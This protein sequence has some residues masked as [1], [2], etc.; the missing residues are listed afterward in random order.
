MRTQIDGN[1]IHE[2]VD[3][4]AYRGEVL[5]IIGTSGGGKTTLLREIIGLREPNGGTVEI[6]GQ[7]VHRLEWRE[8]HELRKRWGMMFQQ[9]ALFSALSVFDNVAFPLRELRKRGEHL[10]DDLVRQLVMFKLQ[11]SGLSAD[12]AN[13]L[14][15]TL[16]GGMIKRVALAR[17]LAVE[18]ELLFLDEPASG[19]DPETAR[20]LDSVLKD[21]HEELNLSVVMVSHDLDSVAALADRIIILAEKRILFEGTFAELGRSEALEQDVVKRLFKGPRGAAARARMKG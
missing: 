11:L 13:K 9:G 3:L 1:V 14:P 12:D 5:A 6:F 8:E 17:A 19:L 15:A 20:D 4:T 10:P 2:Q 16:S 18:A 21:L 7:D